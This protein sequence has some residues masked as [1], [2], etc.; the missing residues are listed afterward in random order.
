MTCSS[1][2]FIG[3]NKS[4]VIHI[5]IDINL[6]LHGNVLVIIKLRIAQSINTSSLI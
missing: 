3:E 6:Y 1:A 4:I 5:S 2:Y